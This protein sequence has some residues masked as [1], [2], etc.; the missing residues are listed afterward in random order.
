MGEQSS[1]SSATKAGGRRAKNDRAFLPRPPFFLPWFFQPLAVAKMPHKRAKRSVRTA[2]RDTLGQDR[3]PPSLS[4][5]PHFASM[6]KGAMRVFNAGKVQADYMNKKRA[7]KENG[8]KANEGRAGG[9][10]SDLKIRPGEK[11]GDFNRRVEQAMASDVA[12][13]ARS[14]ARKQKKRKRAEAAATDDVEGN[15]EDDE[16]AERQ[17]KAKA[18]KA[19][20]LKDAEPSAQDL[21]RAREEMTGQN[22]RSLD[23]AKASQVRRVNDVAD[24]PPVFTKLPR[25]ESKEAKA[26]KASIAAALA[27][28]DPK[29]AARKTMSS[30][31]RTVTAGQ[32]PVPV[33]SRNKGGLRKEK[34]LEEERARAIKLYRQRKELA[35]QQQQKRS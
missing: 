10:M 11:L 30:R 25:G 23:F 35:Q 2:Q 20:A 8:E 7:A 12:A 32:M 19:A 1:G 21:K 9:K 28:Q 15:G 3:V 18:D 24:A 31:E 6:P 34:E 13:T 22:S 4:Q 5:D 27:G 29:V 26:R 17:R 16:D 33:A 14:E